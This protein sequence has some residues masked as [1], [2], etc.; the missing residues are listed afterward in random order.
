MAENSTDDNSNLV[1]MDDLDKFSNIFFGTGK[2][3]VPEEKEEPKEDLEVEDDSLATEEDEDADEGLEGSEED[4]GEE[5]VEEEKPLPKKN[6]KSAKERIEELVARERVAE[7]ERDAERAQRLALEQRLATLEA[8]TK[9]APPVQE[10]PETAGPPNPNALNDKGEPV[11]PLGEFDPSFVRD[12]TRFTVAEETKAFETR[13]AQAQEAARLQAEQATMRQNWEAKVAEVEKE[14]PDYRE[15][16]GSLTSAFGNLDPQYGEYLANTLMQCAN[17][18]EIMYYLSQNIGEA[19]RIV[20]SGPFAATLEIGRL[21]AKLERST[22]GSQSNKKISEAPPP[23]SD[24]T[25]GR[26]GQFAVRPD[27]DDL[28]AFEKE[29]FRKP[30]R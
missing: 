12:L 5:E 26:G 9:V 10:Q 23:P 27:T 19:Q 30:N 7:R 3:P 13:Q 22:E 21:Q 4:E 8:Q 24:R 2:E 15:K 17:G 11:Y 14:L 29:F 20:A 1:D 6:R 28:D 16:I 25:R 18:P